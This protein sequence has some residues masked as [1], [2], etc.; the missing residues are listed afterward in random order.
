MKAIAWFA[1]ALGVAACKYPELPRLTQDAQGSD[2]GGGDIDAPPMGIDA[3]P[4]GA[5]SCYVPSDIGM[6]TIGDAGDPIVGEW[7]H[8]ETTGPNTGKKI[9]AFGGLLGQTTPANALYVEVATTS[10]FMINSPYSFTSMPNTA[11]N[12]Q[13]FLLGDF[14]QQTGMG[15]QLLFAS[16]GT[17]TFMFVGESPNANITG[18]VS[19]T[20]YREVDQTSNA[21]VPGGCTAVLQGVQFY[22]RQTP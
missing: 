21:D 11:F 10:G 13:T 12:A 8:T 17:I 16:S 1:V 20:N 22:L 19:V 9:F 4:D 3:M 7:F 14:N 5:R 15:T 6:L 18:T 2:T